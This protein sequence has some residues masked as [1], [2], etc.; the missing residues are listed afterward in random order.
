[1]AVMII[2][3]DGEEKIACLNSRAKGCPEIIDRCCEGPHPRDN[4]SH[5]I[6]HLRG[7][8]NE[9]SLLHKIESQLAEPITLV[10][11]LERIAEDPAEPTIAMRRGVGRPVP[12]AQ[13]HHL[14]DLQIK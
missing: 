2:A 7:V 6:V 3:L 1:M 4:H 9:A 12:Q 10:V 8:D 5:C 13:I 14:A 11:T